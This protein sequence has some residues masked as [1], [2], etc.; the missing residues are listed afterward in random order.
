MFDRSRINVLLRPEAVGDAGCL[1]STIAWRQDGARSVPGMPLGFEAPACECWRY[2][3][4]WGVV[5]IRT[6]Q[7]C[8]G[9]QLV[10][11]WAT[12]GPSYFA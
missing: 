3:C 7:F 9:F 10:L 12:A 5:V 4:F 6:Q 2:P 11:L 8:C 1:I